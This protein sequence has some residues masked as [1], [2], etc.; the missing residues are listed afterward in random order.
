MVAALEKLLLKMSGK[1]INNSDT[2][3]FLGV[4]L[5]LIHNYCILERYGNNLLDQQGKTKV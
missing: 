4:V 5:A 2:M 3:L 1:M